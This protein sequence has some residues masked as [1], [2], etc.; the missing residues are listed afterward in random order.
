MRPLTHFSRLIDHQVGRLRM[1]MFAK[2]CLSN[3]LVQIL[4]ETLC[5]HLQDNSVLC[6]LICDFCYEMELN[7]PLRSIY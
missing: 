7:F 2:Q 5:I 6:I 4:S 3:I 1:V